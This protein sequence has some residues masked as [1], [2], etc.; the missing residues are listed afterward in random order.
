MPCLA[1]ELERSGKPARQLGLISSFLSGYTKHAYGL[2]NLIS[3]LLNTSSF[4]PN[5]KL[6]ALEFQESD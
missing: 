2:Y 5:T 1:T 3:C 4:S 6:N